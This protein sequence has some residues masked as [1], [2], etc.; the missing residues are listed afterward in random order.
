MEPGDNTL[1]ELAVLATNIKAGLK[2]GTLEKIKIG[3]WLNQARALL[4]SDSKFGSWCKNNFPG[5]G[6]HTRQNYMNVAKTFGGELF[7]TAITIP[8]TALYL[9]ARPKT[10]KSVQKGFLELS[11]LGQKIKTD[12]VKKAIAL[13]KDLQLK[14]EEL[15]ESLMN[16][17]SGRIQ[18]NFLDAKRGGD[19][20][21]RISEAEKGLCVVAYPFDDRLLKWAG[22]KGFLI[23]TPNE[24]YTPAKK[25]PFYNVWLYRNNPPNEHVI[26][27]NYWRSNLDPKLALI[28][29]KKAAS[30]PAT[31][32]AS[33]L[34]KLKGYVLFAEKID[35]HWHGPALANLVNQSRKPEATEVE[36]DFNSMTI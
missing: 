19:Q 16:E 34:Y 15:Y 23:K 10:P 32:F 35:R 2:T 21:K 7:N 17:N 29:Y 27:D 26:F 36:A 5:L 9:L 13:H 4:P 8:D 24:N 12:D 6:R 33:Y 3:D 28:A 31:F 18:T 1:G 14:D 30:K 20:D 22:E 11:S 25:P